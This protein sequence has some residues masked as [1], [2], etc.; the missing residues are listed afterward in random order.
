ML[1]FQADPTPFQFERL[2]PELRLQVY[3][4][5][6]RGVMLA[7][8]ITVT[9]TRRISDKSQFKFHQLGVSSKDINVGI[10][11]VNKQLSNEAIAVL[12]ESRTFDFRTHVG[13][14]E[15]F[16]RSLSGQAR[17]NLGGIAMELYDKAEPD[18]C[19]SIITSWGK[20]PGNQFDWTKACAYIAGNISVKRLSITVNVKIPADFKSLKWVRD[21]VKIRKLRHLTLQINQHYFGGELGHLTLLVGQHNFYDPVVLRASYK[22]GSLWATDPCVSEH[23]IPFFEYLRK[24]MLE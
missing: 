18:Y 1:R 12:Y 4:E 3:R 21:L 19:C 23:L 22:E 7:E 11:T 10:L 2:P 20:G 14:I 16:L 24:E 6:L 5:A 17:L 9:P 8:V 15:P 13:G